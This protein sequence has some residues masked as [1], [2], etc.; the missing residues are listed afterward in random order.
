VTTHDLRLTQGSPEHWPA[1]RALLQS[2]G[3]PQEGVEENIRS[4][5][6]AWRGSEL[7]ATV[8]AEI[9]GDVALVRSLAVRPALQRRGLGRALVVQALEEARKRGIRAVYLLTSTAAGF[10]ARLGF[11]QIPR[12]QAPAA[13][14][15]STQFQGVCPDSA[16]LMTMELVS[17]P[18][19]GD[20]AGLPVAVLGAGPVGL[21]A[22]A[23]LLEHGLD[24]IVFEAMDSVGANLLDYGH[25]RLFSPWRYNVD[26]TMAKQLAATGWAAPD[27]EALPLAR[28]V[29]ERALR[30]YAALPQ[31]AA[32][33][34]LGHRVLSVSREG[35]DK[36]R[37][38][39]RDQAAFVLR[40][41]HGGRVED[42]RVRAVIDSTG[43]WNQP[44]P[45]GANGLPAIG[46][47]A[48]SDRI[49]YRIPDVLGA[50]RGRYAGKRVLVVGSGHSA[51]N[52]L[53]D[54]A[55]LAESNPG[56]RLVWAVRGKHLARAFGGGASDQLPAR[57]ELG[58]R[59]KSL[60]ESG[61]LEFVPEFRVSALSRRDGAITVSG[62]GPNRER[63]DIAGIDEIVCTT[64]QRPDLA[65]ASEL[66]LKLDP[67][68]E[69]NAALGPLIDPNVH[70]CGTVR[71]HGHREVSHPDAGYY[72]LGV[73]SYGRA[74]TFLM[75]TGFEQARSVV[76]ALAG[77]HEAADR[78]ELDLPETGVCG[79]PTG[80]AAASE[81][82]RE[83]TAGCCGPKEAAVVDVPA[84]ASPRSSCCAPA[85]KAEAMGMKQGCCG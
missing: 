80:L 9:H 55:V 16:S 15:A 70:S 10:F 4:F 57:G 36:A 5:L 78:V 82:A 83:D 27:P 24:F 17:L 50:E 47:E 19:D 8:G 37:T 72:T 51:A 46:E 23:H 69:C 45:M 13:M 49:A 7:I 29:V 74:P 61:K 52:A 79:V 39:G 40:V 53:L 6:L 28:D 59:L 48:L 35:F 68:L 75:A 34:R 20:V 62:L 76:A 65:M 67:W 21:A 43:T 32:R 30:P 85:A 64:G 54:L 3:L 2:V 38:L 14:L 73:K 58:A 44:N 33:L 84:D 26:K 66:R 56:T 1:V 25:V 18:S 31:V 81:G 42:I 11:R 77:D 71:P 12:S 22:A 60:A 41:A 63:H